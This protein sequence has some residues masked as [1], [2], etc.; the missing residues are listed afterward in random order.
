MT[1][2]PVVCVVVGDSSI[3]GYYAASDGIYTRRGEPLDTL[4]DLLS[5]L[6]LR[7]ELGEVRAIALTASFWGIFYDDKCRYHSRAGTN[8][9]LY[10]NSPPS[11]HW[12]DGD[13]S[14][15]LSKES[16]AVRQVTCRGDLCDAPVPRMRQSN[17]DQL[18]AM[19]ATCLLLL[20]LLGVAAKLWRDKVP[21]DAVSFSYHS[22]VV[23][24]EYWVR[25]AP[26]YSVRASTSLLPY[27]CD[28][29]LSPPRSRTSTLCTCSST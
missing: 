6:Q 21:V 1:R 12:L 28:R 13:G 4:P 16:S 5:I 27:S 19:P 11:S 2:D 7:R 20:L 9:T 24:G 26:N 17:L 29:G 18:V 8:L 14:A 10:L 23:E 15:A 22:T 3:S 25:T